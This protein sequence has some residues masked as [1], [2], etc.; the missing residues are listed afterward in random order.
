M[1]SLV[2]SFINLTLANILVT[3]SPSMALAK[4]KTIGDVLKN[5]GKEKKVEKEKRDIPK[6]GEAFKSATPVNLATVKP[7]RSSD[8]YRVEGDGKEVEYE[9]LTDRAIKDTFQIV[10]KFKNSP[11][12]GELWVRLAELYVEKARLV[13]FR[14]YR[15]YEGKLDDFESKKTKVK[16][17]LDL[18]EGREYNQRA[19]N[20]YKLFLQDFSKDKKVPQVLFFLGYNYY[21]VGREDEGAKYYKMLTEKYT[22]SIY[23]DESNFALGDYFFEKNNWRQAATHYSR[24][25]NNQKGRHYLFSIYKLSWCKYRLNDVKGALKGMELVFNESKRFKEEER[26][27]K[28]KVSSLRLASEALRDMVPF[29]A[30]VGSYQNA[31]QYFTAMAGEKKA[32]KII[33]KLAYYFTT[34]NIEGARYLFRYLIDAE[35]HSP[36]SF[37]FQYQIVSMY[38]TAGKGSVFKKE[39]YDWITGY[40]PESEWAKANKKDKEL[41]ESAYEQRERTL[42]NYVLGLHEQSRKSANPEVRRQAVEWYKLY[43]GS[44]ELAPS[45]ADMHFYYGELLY[46]DKQYR[47][48]AREYAWV[49]E[50]DKKNKF[51]K[52]AVLNQVISLERIIPNQ[53]AF[54][55]KRDKS[56]K[57][58]PIAIEEDVNRFLVSAALFIKTFPEDSKVGGIEYKIAQ[59]YYLHNNFDKAIEHFTP[60][61]KREPKSPAGQDSI[62]FVLDIY[63]R[64]QDFIR[65]KKASEDLLSIPE[66]AASPIAQQL[67]SVLINSKFTNSV[68]LQ[69]KKEYYAA[70]Q[71][72]EKFANENNKSELTIKALFNAAYNYRQARAIGPAL[73]MFEAVIAYPDKSS[74][75]M[76]LKKDASL[77]LPPLYQ[78]L[79]NYP[80]AAQGFESYALAHPN[81]KQVENYLFNAA[82][83]YDGLMQYDNAIKNYEAYFKKEKR[84]TE[85][86]ESLYYQAEI[87]KKRGNNS[88]AIQLYQ[89]YV[90]SPVSN[91]E[92]IVESHYKL[93]QLYLK[94][95]DK[96][97]ANRWREKTVR[98]QDEFSKT[99]KRI[100]AKYAADAKFIQVKEIYEELKAV[101]LPADAKKQKTGIERRDELTA[102]LQRE[103]GQVVVK[104]TD[105]NTIVASWTLLGLAYM[106]NAQAIKNM[107]LPPDVRKALGSP[108]KI[109]EYQGTIEAQFVKP[110]EQKSIESFHFAI[111]EAKKL[112]VMNDHVIAARKNLNRF[113]P[114]QSL[115]VNANV[116]SLNIVDWMGF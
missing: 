24:L 17:N 108:Q 75:A 99:D 106:N 11:N 50:K 58:T 89:Q 46:D 65:L 87:W 95:G 15:E 18:S 47:D 61:I 3:A 71:S 82:V 103:I 31:P 97:N 12:R 76:R 51:Y 13:K 114:G 83:I 107:P 5:I 112:D 38:S 56:P 34:R 14:R 30:E 93:Y 81:E 4:D 73:N 69:E 21:E 98:V 39:L 53:Q 49:V 29:Y 77:E 10:N 27:D 26:D 66:I 84:Q 1:M 102:K 40:G 64:N 111:E 59:I 33:D 79:G 74:E 68:Q 6:S 109:K 90:Y 45:I 16:P 41:L 72:F 115:F 63:N 54:L 19:I 25:V 116:K 100:G 94:N 80:K 20:L 2:R 9:K 57:N 37:D 42:R 8:I 60:I 55:Q 91:R 110:R 70:G 48:A 86:V 101:Q 36:R 105:G 85:R 113:E 67:K 32:L 35:P 78:Q 52:D 22:K 23:V 96:Q 104:Y 43:L 62:S 88:K 28:G 44:F 92:R 7:P